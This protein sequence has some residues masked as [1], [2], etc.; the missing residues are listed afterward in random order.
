MEARRLVDPIL[1]V[2]DWGGPIGLLA[3]CPYGLGARLRGVPAEHRRWCCRSAFG[4]RRFHR[5]A[6]SPA[7]RPGALPRSGLSP[8]ARSTGRRGIAAPSPATW[9]GRTAGPSGGGRTAPRRSA[10]RAWSRTRPRTPACPAFARSTRGSAPSRGPVELVWGRGT[11]SSVGRCE[12]HAQAAPTGAGDRNRRRALPPG[13]GPGNHRPQHPAAGRDAGGSVTHPL[14]PLVTAAYADRSLLEK[15]GYRE[16]V[17][18]AMAGLDD[19]SLRVAEKG[20][21]R[22]DGQRLGEGGHPPLLRHLRDEGLG[23]RALRVPRQD[24]A[25]EGPGGGGRAGGAA[26]HGALR[27]ASSSRARW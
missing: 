21:G 25:E 27:R 9:P 18:K 20:P 8:R 10:S 1:V 4:A 14:E 17:L 11:P 16:A 23:G 22:L 24:P 19:G 13:G 26:G 6:R 5:L 15:P 2:Q 7:A 12:R 3:A